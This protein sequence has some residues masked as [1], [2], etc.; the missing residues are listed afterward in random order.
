MNLKNKTACSNDDIINEYIKA[1]VQ[2]MMSFNIF[3]IFNLVFKSGVL[4]RSWRE[5]GIRH[6]YKNK[7]V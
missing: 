2:E 7:R 1:T 5:G 6:M 4:S 3:Q